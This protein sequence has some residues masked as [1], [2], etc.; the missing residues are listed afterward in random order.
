MLLENDEQKS[1]GIQAFLD[2]EKSNIVISA[3]HCLKNKNLFEIW[4]ENTK[5]GIVFKV[6]K[7]ILFQEAN[8]YF[9]GDFTIM[10]IPPIKSNVSDKA[11]FNQYNTF[12][13]L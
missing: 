7:S 10:S 1:K 13:N 5:T 9:N 8:S 3:Q 4:F 6:Y 12:M 11:Y 2:Y